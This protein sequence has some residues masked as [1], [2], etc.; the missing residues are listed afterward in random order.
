[1]RVRLWSVK[2]S[3]PVPG[4]VRICRTQRPDRRLETSRR[5]V[6]LRFTRFSRFLL[7]NSVV[8]KGM[9]LRQLG[10]PRSAMSEHD[11]TAKTLKIFVS[12]SEVGLKSPEPR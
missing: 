5:F 12:D 3:T 11:G 8:C 7:A 6:E 1:M 10:V 9:T 2:Q 4:M